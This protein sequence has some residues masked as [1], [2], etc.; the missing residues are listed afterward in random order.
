MPRFSLKIDTLRSLFA[1]SGNQCAFP[2]CKS[3]LIDE[4]NDFI[5]QV[6][7]IAAASEG[8][9]RFD[10]SMSDE[11]RRAFDN[12]IVL[13]YPHHVK[14]NDVQRFPTEIL[15][16]MKRQHEERFS[17]TAYDAPE[18]TVQL[19]MKDQLDFSDEIFDISQGRVKQL[20]VNLG[21]FI[22]DDPRY[23]TY[24]IENC[25]NY[26]ENLLR[27]IDIF[28]TSFAVTN[29]DD[30]SFSYGSIDSIRG[31]LAAQSSPL[32]GVLWEERN[33]G[34]ANSLQNIRIHL[35]SLSLHA[36]IGR[37]LADP[38]NVNSRKRVDEIRMKLRDEARSA[39]VV[40]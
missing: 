22:D 13:C 34:G 28:F 31:S 26:I 7:H 14:T 11:Q 23:H 21:V 2:G 15:A 9:E 10:P 33:I 1:K 29:N 32:Q 5:A 39:F 24:Q 27:E 4:E 3:E 17:K 20:E 16:E 12:L 35:L 19:I 30:L 40:D 18:E 38:S 8:G 36:E 37:M 6:C 25:T